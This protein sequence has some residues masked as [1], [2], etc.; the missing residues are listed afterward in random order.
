MKYYV[1]SDIHGF[2]GEFT[3]A[4]TEAGFFSDSAPHKLVILGDLFDR[5]HEAEELQD[6]ILR[7]MEEDRVILIRGNHEDLFVD[8]VTTDGGVAYRHH[9][10]N[11][12]YSTALQLTGYDSAE[13][14]AHCFDFAEAARNT[15][16]YK[17]IIPAMRDCF[18]TGRYI[19]VHGWIPC[20]R[21]ED[22]AYHYDPEWR[23]ASLLEWERARWYNGM[24]AS[25]TCEEEK[26]VVCGHW[27]A[28]YGHA[29]FEGKGSEFDE[30]ADFSPYYAPGII[31][32]DGCTARSG[33]VNILVLED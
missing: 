21:D 33:Q 19:F 2:C 9:K 28:S 13:A 30:D 15:P 3:A 14:F 12:T 5:G 25:R 32:I 31:A 10:L 23:D 1:V 29:K 26:T 8:L 24:D 6:M 22:G 27:H 11:G 18:E 20:R 16:Y 17:K 4:L 7:M